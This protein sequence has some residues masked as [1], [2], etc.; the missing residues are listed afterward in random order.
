MLTGQD[1]VMVVW[2]WQTKAVAVLTIKHVLDQKYKKRRLQKKK[3]FC[4]LKCSWICFREKQKKIDM[5][6][7]RTINE[8]KRNHINRNPEQL[9]QDKHIKDR[10]AGKIGDVA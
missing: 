2:L 1:R 9:Y 8:R 6:T 7:Q 3:T 10:Q 4:L 5:I